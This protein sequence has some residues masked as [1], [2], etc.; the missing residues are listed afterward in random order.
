MNAQDK[1]I[2][3]VHTVY[4]P[5]ILCKAIMDTGCSSTDP[6]IQATRIII[7]HHDGGKMIEELGD[8]IAR[9]CTDGGA[10]YVVQNVQ[11]AKQ[12]QSAID[13]AFWLVQ[14]VN[15]KVDTSKQPIVS[16]QLQE[17]ERG[18]FLLSEISSVKMMPAQFKTLVSTTE[19]R[20][21]H[22]ALINLL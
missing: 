17:P 8:G 3:V 19:I 11:L 18:L 20:D 14:K 15:D 2:G 16:Y 22:A 4:D 7:K 10:I 1:S 12:N 13:V 6:Q 5:M 21:I 9:I